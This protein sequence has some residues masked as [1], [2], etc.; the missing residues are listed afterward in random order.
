MLPDKNIIP[1]LPDP[2]P[3][4][5]REESKYSNSNHKDWN[6]ANSGKVPALA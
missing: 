4:I 2:E 1:E 3:Q 6:K 5:N